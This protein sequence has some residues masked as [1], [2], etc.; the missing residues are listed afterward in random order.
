MWLE[1]SSYYIFVRFRFTRFRNILLRTADE[2]RSCR[3]EPSAGDYQYKLSYIPVE[4]QIDAHQLA[5]AGQILQNSLTHDGQI[6]GISLVDTAQ[7]RSSSG[8][9]RWEAESLAS[10]G[11]GG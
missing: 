2:E 11:Q 5:Q 8:T 1:F 6:P 4:Y 7:R 9:T 3:T 10:Q